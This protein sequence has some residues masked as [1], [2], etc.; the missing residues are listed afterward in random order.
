MLIV[1]DEGLLVLELEALLEE[2]G[3]RSI[4]NAVTSLEAILLAD[5]LQPDLALVDVQL[6]DGP[7]GVEVARHVVEHGAGLVVFMTGNRGSLPDDL[8]G[9]HGVIAK[10]YS[11]AGFTDALRFLKARL[12][13]GESFAEEAPQSLELGP[14]W[15]RTR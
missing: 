15:Q 8:A 5:R 1:E 9:A 4:G 11:P 10:P 7:T 2:S 12:C 3:F 14:S 13:G 6:L